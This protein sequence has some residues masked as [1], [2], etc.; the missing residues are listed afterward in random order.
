MYFVPEAG[1]GCLEKIP[2][3][4]IHRLSQDALLE[5]IFYLCPLEKF[6]ERATSPGSRV[7]LGKNTLQEM[8]KNMFAEAGI[9]GNKIN[10]S[11]RATGSTEL[12]KRGEDCLGENRASFARSSMNL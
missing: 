6:S 8:V 12:F 3:K 1:E 5:D 9:Q 2:D 4:Y 10:H 11:L 7:P